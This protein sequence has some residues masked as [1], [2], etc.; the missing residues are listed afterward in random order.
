M[1]KSFLIAR[2]NLRRTKG[3]T[4][5]I[6]AL[7]LLASC[8][9]NLWLMLATDY[10]QNFDRYHEKLHAE[11]V[12]LVLTGEDE[13]MRAFVAAILEADERTAEYSIEDA[14]AMVGSFAY[15]GG[16]MNTEFVVLER[17]AAL[18]RPLGRPE[19]VEEGEAASGVYIPMLYGA[20][21]GHKT[22]ETLELTIGSQTREYPICGYLNSVMAGS[23]NCSMAL[24]LLTKD[25]YGELKESGAAPVSTL[26]SVRLWDK[27]E[28]EAFEAMLKNAVSAKYPQV[29]TLSNCYQLV[30]KSRY[31][32]QMICSGVV[33]AMAFFVLVIALVVIVSNVADYIQENMKKL[34]ALKAVGYT[35]GQL[36]AALQLQF[37]GIAALTSAAGAGLSYALFPVVNEIMISQTGI[38]YPLRFLP[39]PFAAAV[40]L[41]SAAAAL[42]VWVSS[43]RIGRIEPIAALR[44]GMKTHSFR[45]NHVPLAQTRMPLHAALALKTTLGSVKRN[46]TICITMLVLSLVVVF[47]GVMVEN[48]MKDITPFIELIVGETADACINVEAERER[49][50]L[51]IMQTDGRVEKA[52]LYTSAEVRH[53]GGVALLA[54]ISD[55]FARV[56]NQNVCFEGRFPRYDNEV[57]VAAKYAREQGLRM[58]DEITLTAGGEEAVFLIS[59]FTQI[60]NNLGKDCLLT[61]GG[62]ERMNRLTNESYYI[63]LKD[64]T[65]IDAFNEEI[66][67]RLGNGVNIVINIQAVING[68]SGVYV[69]MM[70]YIVA[71]ILVLSVLIVSFVLFL[72][73]RTM[74]GNK[75]LDY[76]ILKALGFTTGQLIVQTALSFMPAVAL[77]TAAGLLISALVINPL[78]SVFLSGIGIVECTFAVPAGWTAAAG[79]GL[80]LL[81]FGI[82][83]LLSLKIGKIAPRSLLVGE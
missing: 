73:V 58:G 16:E 67:G 29:R 33:S 65:D 39:L 8:M 45:R 62:Y 63:N 21:G 7:I 25:R 37:V 50:F 71:A 13:E 22:G 40:C 26:V 19:I 61:R 12:T 20:G 47:S 80:L 53:A 54:T 74:L 82:T 57:A 11:H 10:K 28:S 52:Y 59:G 79:C 51:Q 64:G 66:N 75:K 15:N 78:L 23:H 46:V 14:L 6:V 36:L 83:C 55:D 24:L 41:V 69:D 48:M 3:Q 17:Q 18:E 30:S 1:K 5:A 35:S 42:A 43:R 56:N 70:T 4:A 76:G 72:L 60:S 77:S 27:M 2:S 68:T 81:V 31:I 34:G 9:L 44:Q 38:P 32:S 49:D